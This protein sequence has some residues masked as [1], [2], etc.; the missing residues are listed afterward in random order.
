ME[1]NKI[2]V[3]QAKYDSFLEE[4][5]FLEKGEGGEMLAKLLASSPG[6]G[7]GRPNDLPAHI[8]AGE[9]MGYL[10]EIKTIVRKAEI[11]DV[12]RARDLDTDKVVLGSTVG[13]KYEDEDEIVEYTI[14]G[15]KEV[16]ISQGRISCFSPIGNALL[17]KRKG[18]IISTN[19]P[20]SIQ[21]IR[22]CIVR[23]DRRPLD[24]NYGISAWKQKLE[25]ALMIGA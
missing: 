10:Q 9:M 17:G 7:M 6:S 8:L 14:L 11:I 12:I 23:I 24:F 4:I 22:F 1:N 5:D 21:E 15:Q 16:D 19:T 25:N 3:T 18:D 13:V 2:Y 20:G